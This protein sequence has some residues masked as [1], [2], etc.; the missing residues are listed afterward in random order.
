[1]ANIPGSHDM[2]LRGTWQSEWSR[3]AGAIR[4]VA[5]AD[6]F[7]RLSGQM[8]GCA[9]QLLRS[10]DGSLTFRL[11]SPRCEALLGVAQSRLMQCPE[12]LTERVA[13]AQQSSFQQAMQSALEGGTAWSWEGPLQGDLPQRWLQVQAQPQA[14]ARGAR[15]WVGLFL[16][17]TEH[18]ASL[19]TLERA[20]ADMAETATKERLRAVALAE[21]CKRLTEQNRALAE[22]QRGWEQRDKSAALARLALG[23]A[24]EINNPLAGVTY[25]FEA[26]QSG[27]LPAPRQSDYVRSIEAGLRR[28]QD[29]TQSLLQYAHPTPP[30][31]AACDWASLVREALARVELALRARGLQVRQRLRRTQSAI[32]G[33]ASLLRQALIQVLVNAVHASSPGATLEICLRRSPGRLGVEV[34]DHG[35][36]IPAELLAYVCDPFFTTKQQG[37]GTGLGLA[38]ATRMLQAQKG[39]LAIDSVEGE[40]T[41]VTLWAPL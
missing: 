4:R 20:L 27:C 7:E 14:A 25:M 13:R 32:H 28:I 9:F 15:T 8:P 19:S 3:R 17:V 24:H 29:T 11:L 1:M 2:A 10:A 5:Q 34:R 21:T 33:D 16:D 38:S 39:E 12:L 30:Q 31:I 37:E 23:L 22:Q 6:N 35:T 18:H 41:R 40:G 26:L 36:G